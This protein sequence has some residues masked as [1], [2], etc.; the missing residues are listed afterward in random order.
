VAFDSRETPHTTLIAARDGQGQFAFALGKE[1]REIASA[2]RG[3]DAEERR[4]RRASSQ[5]AQECRQSR[6]QM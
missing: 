3:C 2:H 4:R 5:D 6:Q 1:L